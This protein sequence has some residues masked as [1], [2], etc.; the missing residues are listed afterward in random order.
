MVM[1]AGPQLLR[2]KEVGPVTV[3]TFAARS[4]LDEYDV[5]AIGQRLT[6]L[7]D[8]KQFHLVL[9]FAPVERLTSLMLARLVSLSAKVRAA[10]GRVV[11]CRISPQLREV[12]VLVGLT[13]LIPSYET[14]EE[15]L[16]GFVGLRRPGG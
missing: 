13:K 11:M 8:Q 2:V 4:I 1:P 15:A 12:F 14:E 5:D 6:G 9:D 16:Q 3:V 10:G 7:L